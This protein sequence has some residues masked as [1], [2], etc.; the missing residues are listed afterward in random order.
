MNKLVLVATI[1]AVSLPLATADAFVHAGAWRGGGGSW[2][3]WSSRGGHASG[4][5]G[6]W[7]AT[8]YRGGTASGSD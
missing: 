6:S 4:S 7:N 2:G 1:G 3:A 5:D 8:G